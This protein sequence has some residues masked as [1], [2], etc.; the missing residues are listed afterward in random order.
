MHV[1][2]TEDINEESSVSRQ[3]PLDFAFVKSEL[4]IIGSVARS[5]LVELVKAAKSSLRK[6]LVI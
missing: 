1:F 4:A 6:P 2:D 5:L 3:R